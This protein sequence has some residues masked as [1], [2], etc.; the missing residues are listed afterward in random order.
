MKLLYNLKSIC[1][2]TL[3]VKCD[4][5]YLVIPAVFEVYN[6]ETHLQGKKKKKLFWS[7]S[8]FKKL[9]QLSLTTGIEIVSKYS[10]SCILDT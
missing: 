10:E 6:T 2:F 7:L 3:A 4:L 1:I 5:Q 8:P 9:L